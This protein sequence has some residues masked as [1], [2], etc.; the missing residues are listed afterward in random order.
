MYCRIVGSANGNRTRISALK[1]PRANRCTIAPAGFS[2]SVQQVC[3]RLLRGGA[4]TSHT[5]G[6][7][8]RPARVPHT[9]AGALAAILHFRA[10]K[11]VGCRAGK[12]N[13]ILIWIRNHKGSGTPRFLLK[14]LMEG[15]SRSLITQ[16]QLFDFA[17]RG[18]RDGSGEQMFALANIAGEYRFADQPQVESCIVAE[19]LP[20]VWRMPIDE[21]DREAELV[22][23]EITGTHDVRNE[24]LCLN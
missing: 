17:S 4:L 24:E 16:K 2:T 23:V 14:C 9:L 22:C 5:V 1:G 8:L 10:E 6:I 19:D 21:F 20:V 18:N 11:L 13:E 15:D 12:E 7:V 3:N